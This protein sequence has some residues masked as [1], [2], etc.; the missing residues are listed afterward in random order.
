LE[1]KAKAFAPLVARLEEIA[2]MEDEQAIDAAL[3][4]LKADVPRYAKTLGATE[5]EIAAWVNAMGPKLVSGA[6]EAARKRRA[7]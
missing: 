3:V 6:A 1:A 7:N 4:K 5:E 2:G